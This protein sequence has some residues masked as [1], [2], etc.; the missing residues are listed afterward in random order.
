MESEPYQPMPEK[1]KPDKIEID[2]PKPQLEVDLAPVHEAIDARFTKTPVD[3]ARIAA[4][5]EQVAAAPD[6]PV[7]LPAAAEIPKGFTTGPELPR[8]DGPRQILDTEVGNAPEVVQPNYTPEQTAFASVLEDA[9]ITASPDQLKSF[10][11]QTLTGMESGDVL[12]FFGVDVTDKVAVDKALEAGII[13]AMRN[14][15]H[16]EFEAKIDTSQF[17]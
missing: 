6:A 3:E 4:A 12:R 14:L 1:P 13:P 8:N 16:A 2:V 7:D 11:A 17:N 9:G 10:F 15:E 5:R